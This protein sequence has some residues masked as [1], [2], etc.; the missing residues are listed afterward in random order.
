MR[1]AITASA[2]E[3]QIGAGLTR[4]I[5]EPYEQRIADAAG[6]NTFDTEI[7]DRDRITLGVVALANRERELILG[8]FRQESVSRGTLEQLL[9]NV[10]DILDG[11]R[12]EGRIGYNR[13]VRKQLAF[14]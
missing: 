3:Y 1:D 4:D 12:S 13:A 6:H 2:D 9:I 5:K 14:S 11:A 10:E 7:A 8:H